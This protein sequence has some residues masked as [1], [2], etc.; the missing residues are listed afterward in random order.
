MCYN[1]VFENSEALLVVH[2]N[3]CESTLSSY[4]IRTYSHLYDHIALY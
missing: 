1:N 3:T 4:L 2:Q